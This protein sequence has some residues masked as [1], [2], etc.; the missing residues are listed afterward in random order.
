MIDKIS[1]LI[2]RVYALDFRGMIL[3]IVIFQ[4]KRKKILTLLDFLG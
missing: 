2:L 4:L 1:G 3:E